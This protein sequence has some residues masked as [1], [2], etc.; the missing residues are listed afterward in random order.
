MTR[1]LHLGVTEKE[2]V[3]P[4][5]CWKQ[6]RGTGGQVNSGA[7]LPSKNYSK[8]QRQQRTHNVEF[9]EH[10]RESPNR[11]KSEQGKQWAAL[12][13]ISVHGNLLPKTTLTRKETFH[14]FLFP[15]AASY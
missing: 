3:I 1:D 4:R 5:G 15:E 10:E 13:A 6:G 14:Y 7:E 8:S 12:N 9:R 11:L 2:W